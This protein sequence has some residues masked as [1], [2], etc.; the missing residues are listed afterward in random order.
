MREW[1]K[2]AVAVLITAFIALIAVSTR[3]TEAQ[4]G[5]GPWA[6]HER[7]FRRIT[8]SALNAANS[9]Q[10]EIA[11]ARKELLWR[12]EDEGRGD[13]TGKLSSSRQLAMEHQ[14]L[15]RKFFSVM[16]TVSPRFLAKHGAVDLIP[17]LLEM[18]RVHQRIHWNLQWM[19]QWI[20]PRG[21]FKELY[22]EMREIRQLSEHSAAYFMDGLNHLERIDWADWSDR[23][24]GYMDV[25]KMS[26]IVEF[27][28]LAL[29]I[30]YYNGE[31]YHGEVEL[32]GRALYSDLLDA[33]ADINSEVD[34]EDYEILN[35]VVVGNRMNSMLQQLT[36][37]L[38]LPLR[39]G[40]SIVE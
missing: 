33:V 34:I 30:D 32:Y 22:A 2:R 27:S 13:P 15:S 14:D 20:A 36:K 10:Y 25:Q 35:F 5:N 28:A 11:E 31:G 19:S 29:G 24:S 16:G 9:L 23:M 3:F 1:I 26:V 8:I 17:V 12:L 37:D 6:P 40:T 4:I 38:G 39:W 21:L 18:Y 7:E